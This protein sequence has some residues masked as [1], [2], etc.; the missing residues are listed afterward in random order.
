MNRLLCIIAAF[1]ALALTSCDKVKRDSYSGNFCRIATVSINESHNPKLK[2]D[3]TGEDITLSNFKSE[4]DIDVFKARNGERV[5]ADISYDFIP[6]ADLYKYQLNA[7]SEIAIAPL[8]WGTVDQDT[9]GSYF[10]FSTLQLNLDFAYPQIWTNG[11]FLNATVSYYPDPDIPEEQNTIN[12][13]PRSMKGDTLCMLIK[14]VIPGTSRKFSG[15]S[16]YCCYD[17][18]SIATVKSATASSLMQQMRETGKDSLYLEIATCDSLEI[19]EGTGIT[20]IKG[21]KAVVKFALDF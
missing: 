3:Y 13:Y 14:P 6:S 19:F 5:I 4:S 12:L 1:S 7:L 11:H 18:S 8:D 9:L 21:A 2:I 10:H 17:L 16:S 20:R 15:K